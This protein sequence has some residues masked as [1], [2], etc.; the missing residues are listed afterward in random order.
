MIS[1]ICNVL[2]SSKLVADRKITSKNFKYNTNISV[3]KEK[4]EVVAI[5]IVFQNNEIDASSK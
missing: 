4:K 1:L 3:K 2:A 5:R